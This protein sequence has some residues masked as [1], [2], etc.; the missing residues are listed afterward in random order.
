MAMH[1]RHSLSG[2]KVKHLMQVETQKH[3]TVTHILES[4]RKTLSAGLKHS[5]A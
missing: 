1:H 2:V 5:K 3:T 4:H